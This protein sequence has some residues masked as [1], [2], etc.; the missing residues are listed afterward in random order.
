[1]K[2]LLNKNWF[3][4]FILFILLGGG[5]FAFNNNEGMSLE[6]L[7]YTR[8]SDGA[9]ICTKGDTSCI[10]FPDGTS[11]CTQGKR[12][13]SQFTSCAECT[14]KNTKPFGSRCYWNNSESKCG[15]KLK[16]GYSPFCKNKNISQINSYVPVISLLPTTSLSNAAPANYY[17]M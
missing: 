15:S 14:D 7:C 12:T 4:I 5:Y 8:E 6:R 10:Y 9:K 1:M 11:K 13:C 3:L 2:N 17:S 16:K